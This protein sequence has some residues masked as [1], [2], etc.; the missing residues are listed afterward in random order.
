MEKKDCSKRN[1]RIKKT[2]WVLV[3][4]AAVTI[5]VLMVLPVMDGGNEKVSFKEIDENK[6][7]VSITS[8]V[9]PEYRT[10]ER[11][12]ACVADEDIYVL[13]TRGEKPT[14]G[15]GIAIDRLV[16]EEEK[17]EGLLFFFKKKVL[18][19]ANFVFTL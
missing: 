8:E 15:F 1:G 10:L 7:P 18:R 4:A 19:T 6:L 14:S 9:I 3:V 5:A 13:V 11:A 2:V 17:D 12:L 16:L